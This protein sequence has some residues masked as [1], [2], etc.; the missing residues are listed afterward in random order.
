MSDLAPGER[1]DLMARLDVWQGELD[2]YGLDDHLQVAI[3]ALEQGWDEIGLADVMAGRGRTWPLSGQGDWIM[4]R[5]TEARLRVLDIGGRL[6][7]GISRAVTAY[8]AHG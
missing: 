2:G 7:T 6:R 8:R 5:L 1:D 4:E 3:D